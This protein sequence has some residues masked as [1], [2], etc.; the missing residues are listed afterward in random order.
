MATSTVEFDVQSLDSILLMLMPLPQN[1]DQ[2]TMPAT[3]AHLHGS[4]MCYK[5]LWFYREFT[6]LG[7]GC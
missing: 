6:A 2:I 3:K 1:R 7:K 4:F 5:C